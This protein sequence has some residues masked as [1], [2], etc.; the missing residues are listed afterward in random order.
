MKQR[1][2]R[3]LA[4]SSGLVLACLV[5]LT[6]A[7][8]EQQEIR[9]A[10]QFGVGYLPTMIMEDQDLIEKHAKRLGLKGVKTSWLQ[11]ANAAAMNDALLS[12]N[13]DFASGA[14]TAAIISWDR[15]RG[16]KSEVKGVSGES[17]IPFTL[18]TN[19]PEVKTIKD[20]KQGD[21]IAL[22]AVKV[23]T[24]AILLQMEAAKRFGAENYEKIDPLTVSM[25]HPDAIQAMFN[26]QIAAHFTWP[27]YSY[28]EASQEGIHKVVDSTEILDGQP[29]SSTV[30]W[31]RK[32]FHDQHPKLY[33]A[34]I[35]AMHEAVDFIRNN[36][37]ET[38]AIYKKQ[39]K[40]E[41]PIEQILNDPA[42]NFDLAPRATMKFAAFLHS[43]GTIKNKPESWQDVFFPEVHKLDGN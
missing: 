30:I 23:T 41:E 6:G 42:V 21:Q 35:D 38:A 5:P 2:T 40:S 28:V 4:L 14:T 27:P 43:I 9:I 36:K 1:M 10:R 26:K 11:L 18:Y 29:M 32:A 12:G 15:T 22:T 16:T 39:T 8:A 19:K 7:Q 24:Y 31:A 13:L 17:V 3:Y 20:F 37:A 33:Q 34:F 25:A